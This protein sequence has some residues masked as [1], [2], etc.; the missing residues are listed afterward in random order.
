MK[1]VVALVLASL[2][3]GFA[4]AQNPGSKLYIPPPD[5]NQTLTDGT[6]VVTTQGAA[7]NLVLQGE[8]FKAKLPLQ[9]VNDRAQADYVVHWGYIPEEENAS[10]HGNGSLL[11]HAHSNSKELYTVSVSFVGK[12][13]QVVWAGSADKKNL[14]DAAEEITK[15]L[16]NAMKH[17]N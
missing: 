9:M 3:T 7:F 1:Y 14:H 16:K 17:N 10:S 4:Y 12:D 5:P 11:F 13:R 2:A 8:I 6:K 15:Q